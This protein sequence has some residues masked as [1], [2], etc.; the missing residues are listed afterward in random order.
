[1]GPSP[2][3][4][5]A[6]STSESPFGGNTFGSNLSRGGGA[7]GGKKLESFA[8]PNADTRWGGTGNIKPI[9]TSVAKKSDD[10]TSD[11]DGEGEA[12]AEPELDEDKQDGRFRQQ[13]RQS[14]I[15]CRLFSKL[16]LFS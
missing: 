5:I 4:S 2:F 6:N 12:S 8:D 10:E 15:W 7:F 13:D 16:T 9:G 3:G 1:M 11:S 14:Q